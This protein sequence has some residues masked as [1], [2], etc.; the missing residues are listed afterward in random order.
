MKE[1]TEKE[2]AE[3]SESLATGKGFGKSGIVFDGKLR[4]FTKGDT[5]E[6]VVAD[7]INKTPIAPLADA[8]ELLG[9]PEVTTAATGQSAAIEAPEAVTTEEG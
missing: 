7:Y 5:K 9:S 4:K 1:L 2:L 8:E 6:S 3:V